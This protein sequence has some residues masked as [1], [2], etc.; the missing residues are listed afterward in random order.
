MTP[1]THDIAAYRRNLF[2]GLATRLVLGLCFFAGVVLVTFRVGGETT[3]SAMMASAGVIYMLL[4]WRSMRVSREA[5]M[6]TD[7]LARGE[8]EDAERVI[9]SSL[10][11]FSLY[12]GQ[13]VVELYHLAVLRQ[14]QGKFAEAAELAAAVLA[15]RHPQVIGT[16]AELISLESKLE[17]NDLPGAYAMLGRLWRK[18]L[19]LAEQVRLLGSRS[20][21]EMLSG[22]WEHLLW[23]LPDKLR[24]A[25][26]M[27]PIGYATV[28]VWWALAAK[29]LGREELGRWLLRRSLAIG[30][31]SGPV[32]Q[33]PDLADWLSEEIANSPRSG[34]P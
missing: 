16:G 22:A 1:A 17:L 10:R 8:L 33:V 6:A 27:S 4:T 3:G 13:R 31:E 26:Q 5:Q 24:L 25:E 12:P 19:E 15:I 9:K 30:G 18:P 32:S 29:K 23:T 34:S 20:R 2:T 14:G 7:H 21:Y 11:A 28:H